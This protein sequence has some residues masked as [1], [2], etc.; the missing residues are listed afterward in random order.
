[1]RWNEQ[2]ELGVD[3]F[4]PGKAQAHSLAAKT[5]ERCEPRGLFFVGWRG[6]DCRRCRR[7][8]PLII[9]DPSENL[10]NM[11]QNSHMIVTGFSRKRQAPLFQGLVHVSWVDDEVTLLWRC[12]TPGVGRGQAAFFSAA[13]SPP[14]FLSTYLLEVG[15]QNFNSPYFWWNY[16]DLT[17][18]GPQMVA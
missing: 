13:E 4:S 11:V 6:D 10:A 17:R 12:F 2:T 14:I 16:S 8:Q 1:M 18:H 5:Q 3:L 15:R 7:Y 9:P